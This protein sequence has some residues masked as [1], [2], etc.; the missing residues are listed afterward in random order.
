MCYEGI[1]IISNEAFET[2]GIPD[3]GLASFFGFV[4]EKTI[5]T[6][7]GLGACC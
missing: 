2:R 4:I 1:V 5:Q 6:W 7:E 3:L